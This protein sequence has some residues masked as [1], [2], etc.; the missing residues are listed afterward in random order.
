MFSGT[1]PTLS[2]EITLTSGLE[3]V[4]LSAKLSDFT[5]EDVFQVLASY[6]TLPSHDTRLLEL[7][8]RLSGPPKLLFYFLQAAS[9]TLALNYYNDILGNWTK[10]ETLQLNCSEAR[11]HLTIEACLFMKAR[12][13]RIEKNQHSAVHQFWMLTLTYPPCCNLYSANNFLLIYKNSSLVDAEHIFLATV[14]KLLA[15]ATRTKKTCICTCF[16]NAP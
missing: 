13:R 15:I 8:D 4:N 5:A 11:H 12:T 6:F 14:N 16:Q 10:M 1:H 9:D 3:V 7:C 2:R